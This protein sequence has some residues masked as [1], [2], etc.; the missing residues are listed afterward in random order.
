MIVRVVPFKGA[1]TDA[2]T[3]ESWCWCFSF[4]RCKGWCREVAA[5]AVE[6]DAA[7]EGVE[8][9][10]ELWAAR[11]GERVVRTGDLSLNRLCTEVAEGL[12]RMPCA[13]SIPA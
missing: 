2:V 1:V 10:D 8:E 13:G 5:E 9:S 3:E 4:W 6:D 12:M 11:V 7:E